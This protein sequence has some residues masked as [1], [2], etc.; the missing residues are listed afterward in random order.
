MPQHRC[1]PSQS[2]FLHRCQFCPVRP[3][4]RPV[5]PSRP[6]WSRGLFFAFLVALYAF[7][8]QGIIGEGKG[9]VE[10]VVHCLGLP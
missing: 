4:L 2:V 3:R 8:R 7:F 6:H 1:A 9:D 5:L 10:V